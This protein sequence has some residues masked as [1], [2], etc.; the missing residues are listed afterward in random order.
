MSESPLRDGGVY[1]FKGQA[2]TATHLSTDGQ[3]WR[4]TGLIRWELGEEAPRDIIYLRH[5]DGVL[6][7]VTD[8]APIGGLGDLTDT[9]RSSTGEMP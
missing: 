6:L 2:Y 7:S 9:G 1:L 4:S 8:F 3:P 5:D